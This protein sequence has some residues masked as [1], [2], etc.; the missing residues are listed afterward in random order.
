MILDGEG[1]VHLRYRRAKQVE[2]DPMPC[3]DQALDGT[4]RITLR[5]LGFGRK[6]RKRS[7][8]GGEVL[9]STKIKS[10]R[11]KTTIDLI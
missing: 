7:R 4:L 6:V 5:C 9:R 1:K 3:R 2:E 10:R 11:V 8:E